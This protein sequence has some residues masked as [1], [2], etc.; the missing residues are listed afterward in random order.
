MLPSTPQVSLQQ[1]SGGR[2]GASSGE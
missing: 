1:A 2:D